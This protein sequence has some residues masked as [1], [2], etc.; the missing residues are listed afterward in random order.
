MMSLLLIICLALTGIFL[1]KAITL[2]ENEDGEVDEVKV[3]KVYF[4]PAVISGIFSIAFFI[5]V[6]ILIFLVVGAEYPIDKEI[7]MYEEENA[8]IE[9]SIAVAVKSYM[10]YESSI[11]AELEDKDTINLVSSIPELKS[12]T[13]V[14]KQIEIYF[15]NNS[16]IK[17]LKK[18]KIELST[19]KF[20]L[21]FGR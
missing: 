20:L 12:D 9:K 8:S 16:E 7:A 2:Y 4:V 11:Y 1:R 17:E 3:N 13:V 14:Q 18:D 10:D 19:N 6:F 5:Q 21:Y 15:A